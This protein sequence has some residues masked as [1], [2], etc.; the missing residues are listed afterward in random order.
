MSSYDNNMSHSIKLYDARNY[1]K[2]PFQDIAPAP[3]VVAA[4]HSY[5]HMV[6]TAFHRAYYYYK[7]ASMNSSQAGL[8]PTFN[9]PILP[10]VMSSGI[11]QQLKVHNNPQHPVVWNDFEFSA[12]GGHLL[13][14]TAV[15]AAMGNGDKNILGDDYLPVS[16][17][18]AMIIDGFKNDVEPTVILRPKKVGTE[19]T[20]AT[21]SKPQS[22]SSK[23]HRTD[24]HALTTYGACFSPD[25]K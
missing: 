16:A 13:V 10:S 25:G 1:D 6:D 3:S 24:P 15:P 22:G 17:S 20:A 5:S 23:H 2:G 14:N 12:E 8:N 18:V 19:N 4:S 7:L 9:L 21:P 11:S